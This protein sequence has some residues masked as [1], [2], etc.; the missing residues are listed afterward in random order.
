MLGVEPEIIESAH[1]AKRRP[2]MFALPGAFGFSSEESLRKLVREAAD[3]LCQVVDGNLDF[4]VR[5]AES[6]DDMDKFLLLVNFVLASARRSFDDLRA[7]NQR[8]ETDLTTARQLQENLLPQTLEHGPNLQIGAK[9]VPAR[10]VGGDFFDFLRYEH[11]GLYAGILADVS[12][13]GAAAAIYAALASGMV[14]WLVQEELMPNE[15]LSKLNRSLFNRAP[16]GQ[17][18][19]MSYFTWDDENRLLQISNSG[20][21]EPLLCRDGNIRVLAAHGLPLGLFSNSAYETMQVQCVPGDTLLFYTDGIVDSVDP[22]GTEFGTGRLAEVVL[23]SCESDAAEIV[24]SV[25]SNVH[26]YCRCEF[27]VDDQTV[28]AMRVL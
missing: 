21:P 8:L 15:M 22:G 12:G 9:F 13:K 18:V 19:A 17:F 23:H 1:A 4:I 16:E 28:L 24:D 7:A 6:D 25:I 27:N 3:Q 2:E 11:R 26:E 14:R 20:L 10:T 5:V